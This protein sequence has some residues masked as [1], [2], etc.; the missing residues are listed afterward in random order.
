VRWQRRRRFGSAP[1][2]TLVIEKLHATLEQPET[3]L[4]LPPAARWHANE[5]NEERVIQG[6]T[7][8]SRGRVDWIFWID[9]SEIPNA[10]LM[11]AAR[12]ATFNDERYTLISIRQIKRAPAHWELW[13]QR[14]ESVQPVTE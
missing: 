1:R 3:L 14:F 7:E 5:V 11:E 4:T 12:Y 8:P 2:T 6:D 9:D 10:E 13:A